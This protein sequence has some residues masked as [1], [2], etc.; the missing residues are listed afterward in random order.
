MDEDFVRKDIHDT[1]IRRIDERI[2]GA[3]SRIESKLDLHIAMIDAMIAEMKA[4]NTDHRA[5]LG[6]SISEIRGNMRELQGEML[7]LSAKVDSV[8]RNVT[9]IMTISGLLFALISIFIQMWR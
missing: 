6:A 5:N 1:E 7:A 2:T 8:T 9:L 3:V 4:E